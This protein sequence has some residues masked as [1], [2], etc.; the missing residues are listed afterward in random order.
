MVTVFHHALVND[1]MF[2]KYLMGLTFDGLAGKHQNFPHQNL[3]Y[4]QNR[5]TQLVTVILLHM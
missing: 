2:L 1:V 5:I 3:G 4:M